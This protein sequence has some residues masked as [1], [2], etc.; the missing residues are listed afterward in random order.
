[1][2]ARTM[3][4]IAKKCEK[5][6]VSSMCLHARQEKGNKYATAKVEYYGERCSS[7]L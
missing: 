6:R 5:F 7:L 3:I 2:V 4:D 1:M